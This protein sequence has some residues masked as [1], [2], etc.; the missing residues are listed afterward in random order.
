[1]P[2]M[3][4]GEKIPRAPEAR[5]AMDQK[6]ADASFGGETRKPQNIK[7]RLL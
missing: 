7:C 3:I 2:G 5:L 1:M 4:V 6:A